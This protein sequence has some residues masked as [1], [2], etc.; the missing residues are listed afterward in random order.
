[1]RLDIYNSPQLQTCSRK[2]MNKYGKKEDIGQHLGLEFLYQHHGYLC[3]NRE[4][5]ILDPST[6]HPRLEVSEDGKCVR[7][8]GDVL[9]VPYSEGRFDSHMFVLAK[10]GFV[11]GKHYWEV[12]V[13]QKKSWDLGVASESISRKGRIT[14]APQNGYWVIGRDGKKD[15][16]ARTNPWTRLRAIGKPTKIG[17]FLDMSRQHLSFYDVNRKSEL[18]TFTI[19]RF[20]TLY[21]FFSLGSV[22]TELDSQ[23][24]KILNESE[25]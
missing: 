9:K 25:E 23:Q 18:Y 7:D 24:L 10:E 4:N 20:G 11:K 5:V 16:W 13:G 3:E 22:T 19:H 1:M 15:Y 17:M 6:A 14:L 2:N 8:T 21:P 12:E